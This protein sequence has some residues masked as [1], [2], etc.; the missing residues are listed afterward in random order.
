[1]SFRYVDARSVPSQC[2]IPGPNATHRAR[3]AYEGRTFLWTFIVGHLA[4]LG[5][6]NAMDANR[7]MTQR[8]WVEVSL[9]K[10]VARGIAECVRSVPVGIPSGG[11]SCPEQAVPQGLV[12]QNR[13]KMSTAARRSRDAREHL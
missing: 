13:L 10:L 1:M 4:R 5:S 7:S 3:H 2:H 12:A 11:L 6:R 9:Q 8:K